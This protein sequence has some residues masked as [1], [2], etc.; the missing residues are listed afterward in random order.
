MKISI[1]SFDMGHNCL[2]RAYLLGRVLKRR[3]DVEILGTIPTYGTTIWKP[4]DTGEFKYY[5]VHGGR[6]FE[7][8]ASVVDL[9]KHIKGDVIYA[10][11]LRSSSFGVGILKK[12]SLSSSAAS[13][14][15]LMTL[16]H[17]G[18]YRLRGRKVTLRSLT[19]P[20]GYHQTKFMGKA[21]LDGECKN[22]RFISTPGAV[23]GCDR[24]SR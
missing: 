17:R 4:C 6:S 18:T 11:K 8:L 21:Y 14:L 7:Y 24:S 13:F 22:N 16:R 9:V 12:K 20:L 19:N 2:G 1:I 10:S 23:R 3:Y 5:T 15:I